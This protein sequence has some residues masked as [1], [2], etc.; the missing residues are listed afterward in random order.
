[1][2][3]CFSIC[4]VSKSSGAVQERFHPREINGF[5]TAFLSLA[6]PAAK[7]DNI[8]TKRR[9]A[10]KSSALASYAGL[11]IQVENAAVTLC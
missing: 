1:M 7:I 11:A 8:M 4:F 6:Q 5:V 9:A 10:S 2:F 3:F